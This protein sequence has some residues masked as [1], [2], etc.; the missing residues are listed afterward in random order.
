MNCTQCRRLLYLDRDA[1][2]TEKERAALE[3]HLASCE[4]CAREKAAAVNAAG[5]VRA[6][7]RL[8]FTPQDPDT[9]VQRILERIPG[10]PM[11]APQKDQHF[12]V[13]RFLEFLMAP[14]FRVAAAG[15]IV[16]IMS[17]FL[18]QSYEILRDVRNLEARQEHRSL[19]FDGPHLEYAI[20]VRPLRGTPEG[21]L[22]EKVKAPVDGGYLVVNDQ[23]ASS[24]RARERAFSHSVAGWP[25]AGSQKE[26]L[27][28]LVGYLLENVHP[29]L[30]FNREG[31]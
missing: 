18:T 5:F 2:L 24:L 26:T 1:D 3:A 14:A 7:S 15:F 31:V 25:V 8:A 13:D 30:S 10:R 27:Q 28:A 21:A 20:D 16:L 29:M 12:A 6:A 9:L 17:S 19:S 4:R 22:L 23:E 11:R